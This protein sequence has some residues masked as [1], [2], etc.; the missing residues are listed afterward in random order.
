MKLRELMVYVLLAV[1]LL[2]SYASIVQGAPGRDFT[3]HEE[4]LSTLEDKP[5]FAR[6][7]R[8]ASQAIAAARKAE[9]SEIERK[10]WIKAAEVLSTKESLTPD[11]LEL[12]QLCHKEER[13][14]V[15]R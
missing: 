14:V 15:K 13:D 1:C 11:A 8:L 10:Y 5:Q 9:N 7:C 6:A 4:L 3:R 12:Y 2:G